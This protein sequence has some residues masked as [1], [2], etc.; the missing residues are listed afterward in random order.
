MNDQGH[1]KGAGGEPVYAEGD[2]REEYEEVDAATAELL[3][4]ILTEPSSRDEPRDA[5][6]D[7]RPPR[8]DGVVVGRLVEVCEGGE[9]VVQH[10]YASSPEGDRGRSMTA[11]AARDAGREVA[12]L[13]EGGAPDRPIVMGLMQEGGAAMST[14][15]GSDLAERIELNAEK[16]IVLRCG[17]ASITLT[18]AGK[19]VIRGAYLLARAT[20]VNRIQGGSVEIN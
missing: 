10:R 8:I 7:A 15:T 12:L 2:V 20:G 5:A 1:P 11:L 3:E 6:P 16:E 14:A 19:I 13:F 17:D 4:L 18:R 9:V